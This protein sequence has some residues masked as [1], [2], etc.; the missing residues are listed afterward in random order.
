MFV[1]LPQTNE[2]LE[3][4]RKC[5][6]CDMHVYVTGG[7]RSKVE[8][9]TEPV[10]LFMQFGISFYQI[11]SLSW[12]NSFTPSFLSPPFPFTS[13]SHLQEKQRLEQEYEALQEVG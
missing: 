13:L 4:V 10:E 6:L 1:S 11:F 7:Q 9:K 12:C 5:F 2:A 8:N 3:Q